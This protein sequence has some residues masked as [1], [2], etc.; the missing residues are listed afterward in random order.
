MLEF[1]ELIKKVHPGIFIHSVRVEETIEADQRAGWVKPFP[2]TG[3]AKEAD[4]RAF[5]VWQRRRAD[6]ACLGTIRF[7]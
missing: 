4:E 6:C 3:S 7:H 5:A 2:A 1:M